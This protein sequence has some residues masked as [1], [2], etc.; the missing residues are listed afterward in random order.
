[1]KS[2]CPRIV[3]RW[4]RLL[5][6]PSVPPRR[7]PLTPAAA[8][9]V[10]LNAPDGAHK[11]TLNLKK[12]GEKLTGTIGNNDGEIPVEGSQTGSDVTV[13]FTYRGGDT[14]MPITMKGAQKG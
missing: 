14:P 11:A 6:W 12:D 13:S 1:M 10:V 4:W 2:A 8:W 3:R 9:D 7:R 5:V